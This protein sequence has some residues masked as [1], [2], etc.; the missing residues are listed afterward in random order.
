MLP[1]RKHDSISSGRRTGL[2][3]WAMVR[4]ECDVTPAVSGTTKSTDDRTHARIRKDATP[5]KS[6]E[7]G[8]ALAAARNAPP[9]PVTES[10]PELSVLTWTG[11]VGDVPEWS[12]VNESEAM[13]PRWSTEHL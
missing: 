3:L 1:S 9:V 13:F 5:A 10:V 12:S 6:G 11:K 8:R 7:R 2:L 4:A